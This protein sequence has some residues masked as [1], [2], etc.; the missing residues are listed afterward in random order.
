MTGLERK[1]SLLLN[2]GGK[3]MLA[4]FDHPQIF[5]A[6][7]G[8]LD[9][10]KAIEN[11]IDSPIDGFIL[12]PGIFRLTAASLV[13]HKKM[14]LR[15]SL[16]GTMMGS[17]FPESHSVMVSPREAL[18]LGADGVLIMLVLG[19]GEDK[20][21]MLELARAAE[22]FHLYGIPVI[23]EVLAADYKRN[24]ETELIRNGARIAAELG[25]DMVKAF[26]CEDFASVVEA[27][28]VP[29]ILAGGPRDSDILKVAE[30]AVRGGARG[31]AFGRNIFQNS[32]PR[33]FV[34]QLDKILHA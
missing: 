8:L 26:F 33:L 20:E 18:N 27:C 22:S 29:V 17:S 10:I 34:S 7:P 30:T 12:N 3:L 9:P 28:P 24:N 5:G 19:G 14:I 6:M 11:L 15:A 21:S 32:D 23:A 4:A 16:G 31:F 1:N 13:Q 25:A 2:N